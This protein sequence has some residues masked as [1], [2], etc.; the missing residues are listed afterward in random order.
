MLQRFDDRNAAAHGCLDQHIH[1]LGLGSGSNLIAIAGDHG[2]VGGH[3]RFAGGNRPQDQ[4]AGRLQATHHLHHNL[5]G[6]VVDH[7]FRIGAEQLLGDRHGP[8]PGQIAHGHPFEFQVGHQG[9][10]PLGGGQDGGDACPHRAQTQQADADG[11][12]RVAVKD[13]ILE[14]T[15]ALTVQL[16]CWE[17]E[18]D[19]GWKRGRRVI[20]AQRRQPAGPGPGPSSS[21]GCSESHWPAMA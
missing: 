3:H 5:H 17:L 7:G 19:R 13:E 8:G 6:R 20:G 4:G 2:L 10:A 14:I 9:M 15:G 12:A 18:P 21:P 11:H 1:P 16:G